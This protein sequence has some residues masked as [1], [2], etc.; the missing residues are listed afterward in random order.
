MTKQKPKEEDRDGTEN[1]YNNSVSSCN[2]Q[3]EP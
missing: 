2:R 3:I 1:T